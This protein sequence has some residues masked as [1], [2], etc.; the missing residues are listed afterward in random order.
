MEATL[1][2]SQVDAVAG[3]NRISQEFAK[4]GDIIKALAKNVDGYRF[5]L[6]RAHNKLEH[7]RAETKKATIHLA[8]IEEQAKLRLSGVEASHRVLID[9]LSKQEM[10]LANKV[11]ENEAREAILI[12]ERRETA[13]LKAEYER[14]IEGMKEVATAQAKA[15]AKGK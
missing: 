5:E 15:V 11:K 13:L 9:R 14:R 2:I 1:E 10:L 7:V 6:V 8:K 4:A 3:A 12:A